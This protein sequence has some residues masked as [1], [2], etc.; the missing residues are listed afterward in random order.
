MNNNKPTKVSDLKE[1]IDLLKTDYD[2][3][4]IDSSPNVNA[5]IVAAAKASDSLV[6]I[7]SPD[8]ASISCILKAIFIS[9]ENG[10][11]ID[12]IILNK[13]VNSKHEVKSEEVEEIT[14]LKVIGVVPYHKDVH[15]SNLKRVCL[16]AKGRKSYN[17]EY[18]EIAKYM[19]LKENPST[20]LK[21]GAGTKIQYKNRKKL[22]GGK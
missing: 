3:I 10:V 7:V 8:Y 13:V 17:K 16:P 9:K 18:S 20:K 21:F 19:V 6:M 15:E 2:F 12:G 5:E 14:G 4:L 1:H 22:V 11:K